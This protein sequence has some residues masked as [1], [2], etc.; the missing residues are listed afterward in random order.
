LRRQTIKKATAA[1]PGR[2]RI[3]RKEIWPGLLDDA[4]KACLA[5]E[6]RLA[7]HEAL[8]EVHLDITY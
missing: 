3:P 4:D 2:P 6:L 8:R 5:H 1:A 7:G